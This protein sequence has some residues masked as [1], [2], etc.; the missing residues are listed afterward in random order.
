MG[1]TFTIA[2]FPTIVLV[3]DNGLNLFMVEKE[4]FKQRNFAAMKKS[5]CQL[6]FEQPVYVAAKT[7][8]NTHAMVTDD[9]QF[10]LVL[11]GETVSVFDV[12]QFKINRR[13][14]QTQKK[15]I[16]LP[17]ICTVT[18]KKFE[19]FNNVK[20]SDIKLEL[21]ENDNATTCWL[22]CQGKVTW[23]KICGYSN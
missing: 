4:H 19:Q 16:N 7:N 2:A 6:I 14:G 22:T 15:K 18:D 3:F 21:T 5:Y 11:C 23:F 8:I 20:T 9:Q 13:Y 12:L 10:L 1:A 17:P